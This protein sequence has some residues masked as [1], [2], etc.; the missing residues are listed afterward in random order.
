MVN[1]NVR[2]SHWA[3][4]QV[5][6]LTD[7]EHWQGSVKVLHAK[8]SELQAMGDLQEAMAYYERPFGAERCRYMCV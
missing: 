4:P 3:S 2:M 5:L 6:F 8:A 1:S 7:A